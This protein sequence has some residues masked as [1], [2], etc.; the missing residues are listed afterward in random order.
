MYQNGK[1]LL[2]QT[3]G[4]LNRK[5][6]TFDPSLTVSY[7][8]MELQYA[9][10]FLVCKYQYWYDV[11]LQM[12]FE[13]ASKPTRKCGVPPL[14]ASRIVGGTETAKNELPYQ[15][16]LKMSKIGT[17]NSAICGGT[18]VGSKHVITAAHCTQEFTKSDIK[19]ILGEHYSND[20]MSIGQKF[21]VINM[22]LHPEF[23]KDTGTIYKMLV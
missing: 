22:V 3:G 4:Y 21:S 6:L 5:T 10:D 2:S 12:Y 14:G 16:L 18:L 7:L 15:A 9:F 20:S 11:T 17:N 23:S 1:L 13:S 8:K 19:V